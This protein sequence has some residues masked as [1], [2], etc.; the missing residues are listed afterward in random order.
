MNQLAQGYTDE[1]LAIFM[2][3]S[4]Y[5]DFINIFLDVLRLIASNRD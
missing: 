2:A 3:L 1:K 5:L 4:L